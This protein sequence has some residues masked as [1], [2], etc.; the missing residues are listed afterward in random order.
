M[1]YLGES[2]ASGSGLDKD[3]LR[4]LLRET[5][6]KLESLGPREA[7]T[8]PARRGDTATLA[9]HRELLRGKPAAAIYDQI[10]ES[11]ISTYETEL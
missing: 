10:T 2:V 7:Q 8:G 11:I 9:K 5:L 6:A 1:V 4:P 3:L